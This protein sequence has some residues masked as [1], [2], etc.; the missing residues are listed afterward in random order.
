[1]WRRHIRR[2]L[3][4]GVVTNLD[5]EWQYLDDFIRLYT[6]TMARNN[7]APHYFFDRAHVESLQQALPSHIHLHVA[8]LAGRM[9]AAVLVSEYREIAQYLYAGVNA[10]FS[11]L[12]PLKVLLASVASWAS[13]R[14]NHTIHLG[15]GRGAQESDSLFFFKSGFSN[16]RHR[17]Y[18]G[19]WILNA[20]IYASLCERHY[21]G[22]PTTWSSLDG[23]FPAYREPLP[24]L[25]SAVPELASIAAQ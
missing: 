20:D 25:P 16:R 22:R 9:A 7:A 1:M 21:A 15:G 18:T 23:F 10:A 19:R 8:Q 12:S 2:A 13:S 17:F 4:A 11:E 14:G 6:L 24:N 3:Q 5:R